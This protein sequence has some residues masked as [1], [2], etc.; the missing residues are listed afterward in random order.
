MNKFANKNT[1]NRTKNTQTISMVHLNKTTTNSFFFLVFFGIFQ[2]RRSKN[3]WNP[4]KNCVYMCLYIGIYFYH[5]SLAQGNSKYIILHIEK[6]RLLL[7]AIASEFYFLFIFFDYFILFFIYFLFRL[8]NTNHFHTFRQRVLKQNS[9]ICICILH[10]S[11]HLHNNTNNTKTSQ[12]F[13]FILL[14]IFFFGGFSSNIFPLL[15]NETTLITYI[16]YIFIFIS[17]HFIINH[18]YLREFYKYFWFFCVPLVILIPP[19][20]AL[21]SLGFDIVFPI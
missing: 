13:Y 5:G 19:Q 8:A 6:S 9:I 1:T 4:N 21:H 20:L 3:V 15:F 2:K 12:L 14:F 7:L 18:F 10:I 17:L 16:N 11:Q